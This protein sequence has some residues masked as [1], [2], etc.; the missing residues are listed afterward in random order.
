MAIITISRQLGS[1]GSEIAQML[2]Q[3]L[4]YRLLN[5]E[6]LATELRQNGIS[7]MEKHD[8]KQPNFYKSFSSKNYTYIHFLQSALFKFAEN[9]RCI[10][11]GRGGQYLLGILPGT[12]KLNITA[13]DELRLKRIK[14]RFSCGRPRPEKIMQTSDRERSGFHNFFFNIDWQDASQYDLIMSTEYFSPKKAAEIIIDSLS[15]FDTDEI[16]K[17]SQHMLDNIRLGQEIITNIFEN[18]KIPVRYL[19]ASAEDGIGAL[20]GGVMSSPDIDVCEHA[21][22][23]VP[24]VRRVINRVN[25]INSWG[26][27]A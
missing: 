23:E 5:K 1:Q 13:P 16:H 6:N 9:G 8:E 7:D 26:G 4:N 18:K 10:I 11:L 17:Q 27:I 20:D 14:V 22:M 25:C 21:A 15:A 12:M 24:G 19:R 2:S 3:Q